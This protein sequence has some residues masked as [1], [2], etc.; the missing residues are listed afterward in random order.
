MSTN[1]KYELIGREVS[2]DAAR[3][4]ALFLVVCKV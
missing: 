4:V 2:I 3:G 1:N